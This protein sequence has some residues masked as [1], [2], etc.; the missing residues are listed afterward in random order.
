MFSVKLHR[1]WHSGGVRAGSG[2]GGGGGG[3]GG[4]VCSGEGGGTEKGADEEG[5]FLEEKG[6]PEDARRRNRRPFLERLSHMV[7]ALRTSKG[8]AL[9]E[10]AALSLPRSVSLSL[11]LS[12]ISLLLAVGRTLSVSIASSLLISVYLFLPISLC[13]FLSLSVYLS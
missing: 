11:C 8:G 3:G 6:D 2:S 13:S 7:P 12:L 5:T 1:H 4:G 10:V 9:Q